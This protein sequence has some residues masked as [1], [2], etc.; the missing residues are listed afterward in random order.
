M[1]DEEINAIASAVAKLLEPKFTH[2]ETLA[3]EANSIARG[4]AIQMTIMFGEMDKLIKRM[5][6]LEIAALGRRQ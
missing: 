6:S 5:D 3:T 2:I 1:T 4:T